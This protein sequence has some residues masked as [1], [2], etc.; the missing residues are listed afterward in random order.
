MQHFC[1]TRLTMSGLGG[2]PMWGTTCE[3]DQ[4][5]QKEKLAWGTPNRERSVNVS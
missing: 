4:K 2:Q 3:T 5:G 1:Y